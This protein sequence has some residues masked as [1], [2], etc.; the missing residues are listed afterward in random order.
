MKD[1]LVFVILGLLG[2]PAFAQEIVAP[3]RS[4]GGV[5]RALEI[6]VAGGYS[7]GFGD[8]G[9][10][11]RS[12]TDLSSAGG[13]VTLGV[14]YRIDR[15]FALGVYG[16]GGKYSTKD[17]TSG[18]DIW[19]ATA[20]LQGSVHLMPDAEWDPWVSVGSGWRGYWIDKSGSTDSRHGWDIGRLTA[21]VDYRV[22][23]EFA[24][25]PYVGAGVTTFL[26]QQL[27]S[28][29]SFSNVDSPKVN[30]WLFAGVQGRFDLFG[31][32]A[33]AIRLASAN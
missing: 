32:P 21:G 28:Q 22:S 11:Q 7:Q 8:I 4:Q 20:G 14:G 18:A 5:E 1:T 33:E 23:P 29:Q 16:S 24:V 15:R 27:A 9:N 26:T 12:L 25:S 2:T 19:T 17:L 31:R 6:T 10:G 3:G 30:V 13:E